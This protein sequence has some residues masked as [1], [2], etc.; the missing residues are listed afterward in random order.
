MHRPVPA[1][2]TTAST[3][4]ELDLDLEL[5]AQLDHARHDQPIDPDQTANVILHP[6]FLL[7]R[8]FDNAK[9]ARGS[10]CLLSDP[11]PR[12]INKTPVFDRRDA[13]EVAVCEAVA[14]AFQRED[15]GV[16]PESVD[17]RGGR[18]LVAEDLAPH[19]EWLV[20]ILTAYGI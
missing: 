5:L 8:V 9:P 6:L 15:F 3:D 2:P 12:S 1:P 13:S 4:R 17:H 19:T 11:Q 18:D 20:A 10:G 7:V 14:V 16:V